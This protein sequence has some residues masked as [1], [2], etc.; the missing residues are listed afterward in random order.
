MRAPAVMADEGGPCDS[1]GAGLGRRAAV[2]AAEAEG[3]VRKK[4]TPEVCGVVT[5]SSIETSKEVQGPSHSVEDKRAHTDG[6]TERLF[7]VADTT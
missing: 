3:E 7:S 1:N 4:M 6:T 5:M 2:N